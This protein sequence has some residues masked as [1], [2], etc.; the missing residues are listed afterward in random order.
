MGFELA[1]IVILPGKAAEFEA[2]V[3]EA[4]PLFLRANGCGGVKLHLTI[5][6][7]ERYVLQV[8]WANIDDHM[9]TFRESADF[10]EWR[11]LVGSCFKEPPVV[12]HTEVV[13]D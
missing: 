1:H 13:V 9:I 2:G 12:V 6:H 4:V 11:S 7:P 8:R 5:E 10:Q 3:G